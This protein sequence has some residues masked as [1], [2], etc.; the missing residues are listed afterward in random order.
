MVARACQ[1]CWVFWDQGAVDASFP[2]ILWT[3]PQGKQLS[4]DVIIEDIVMEAF[5]TLDVYR[6][7]QLIDFGFM[8]DCLSD[9]TCAIDRARFERRK[10]G[11]SHRPFCWACALLG[12][13]S[14]ALRMACLLLCWQ[15][16]LIS[17][18]R[19]CLFRLCQFEIRPA[20]RCYDR[21]CSELMLGRWKLG[22]Y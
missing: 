9:E 11:A 18:A 3:M 1:L 16:R 21:A 17:L 5:G 8:G 20:H 10:L 22:L 19:H 12:A 14:D 2:T 6:V 7:T 4:G 13:L 15:I